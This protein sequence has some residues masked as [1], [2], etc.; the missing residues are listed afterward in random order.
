MYLYIV[1]HAW[2][3]NRDDSRWPDDGMRPLTAEGRERFT[4]VVK[5]LVGGGLTP[6]I[7]A[8]S[9]LVRCVETAQLLAAALLVP[10]PVSAGR[11]AGG[12]G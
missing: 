3:A 9:P 10:F 1:R 8:S 2:A 12:G 7:I 6:G 5:R 11:P 4:R